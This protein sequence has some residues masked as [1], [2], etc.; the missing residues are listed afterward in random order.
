MTAWVL[1][2]HRE[3]V[4]AH[5][6]SRLQF[7]ARV[8]ES[9]ADVGWIPRVVRCTAVAEVVAVVDLLCEIQSTI[10]RNL[11][12]V[13]IASVFL[14]DSGARIRSFMFQQS[15]KLDGGAVVE[16]SYYATN[17]GSL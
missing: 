1:W 16:E 12:M 9:Q 6:A 4:N 8:Q 3:G 17:R 14:W 5:A 11:G 13:D 10:L 7:V 15:Y 2:Q